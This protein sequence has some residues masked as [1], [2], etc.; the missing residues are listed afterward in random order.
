M[1]WAKPYFPGMRVTKLKI[2][3]PPRDYKQI[4]TKPYVLRNFTAAEWEALIA[5]AIG[6]T[7]VELGQLF[8]LKATAIA[9]RL[10][11]IPGFRLDPET[12][13]WKRLKAYS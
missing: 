13:T 9:Q 2:L 6:R 11:R 8:K 1:I 4:S 7:S 5:L 12:N 3:Q 10:R